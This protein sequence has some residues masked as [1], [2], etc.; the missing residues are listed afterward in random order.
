MRARPLRNNNSSIAAAVMAG[1]VLASLESSLAELNQQGLVMIS[2]IDYYQ[3]Y[4]DDICVITST[5][6]EVD[7]CEVWTNTIYRASDGEPLNS[8][9]PALLPQT[10]TIEQ[11]D[12]SW[13][14]TTVQFHDVASFCS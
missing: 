8:E 14:I 5:R 1:E 7:T 9:G 3:S 11:L 12:S 13:Y 4:I 6:I 2:E 10:I